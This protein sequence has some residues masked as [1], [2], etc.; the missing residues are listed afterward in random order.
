[1]KPID[2][3]KRECFDSNVENDDK[4]AKFEVG[5]HVRI[6]KYKKHFS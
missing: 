6:L 4:D 3:T 2:V 5:D 1:M